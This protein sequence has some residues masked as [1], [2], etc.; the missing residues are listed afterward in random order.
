MPKTGFTVEQIVATLRQIDLLLAQGK[1]IPQVRKEARISD[2]S[3]YRFIGSHAGA[4]RGNHA[5]DLRIAHSWPYRQA[6]YL[7]MDCFRDRKI[8]P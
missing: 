1:S 4:H 6:Q 7:A 3:N 2:V 5:L 8:A